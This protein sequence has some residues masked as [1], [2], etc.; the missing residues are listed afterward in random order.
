MNHEEIQDLLEDYVDDRLDRQTRKMV[1]DHL[2]G[3]TECR[4]ILDEVAPVDVSALGTLS[5]D[6]AS[7]RRIVRRS[8][9]RTAW[10][11][12]L[13]LFAGWIALWFFAALV[14]QPLAVNRGG[15]AAD[16]AQATIDLGVMLNQGV[17]LT[18]GAISSGLVNRQIDLEFA[19]A[20][21]AGLQPA[22]TTSTMVGPFG[23]R[24]EPRFDS[25]FDF[26]G[27]QGD[28][29]DQL[30]NLGESTV[31]TVSLWF[32]SPVSIDEAQAIADDPNLDFRVVWAGFDAS[33]DRVEPLEPPVW[34]AGGTLGYATCVNGDEL[35]EDL[36]GATSA[37]FG[38][39][40]GFLFGNSSIATARDS[41]VAA[42]TN[43][44]GRDELVD[45][46]VEPFDDDRDDFGKIVAELQTDPE[47]T[48]LVV[49]GPSPA[50]AEY[51]QG[52]AGVSAN[53]LAVDFYNWTT[54]VCGR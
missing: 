28:A 44:S 24:D 14:L 54:Q 32:D 23:I 7:M 42:L 20:V 52:D 19:V 9:F 11:T 38:Q 51:L 41:V 49:T 29:L 47:V 39:G 46:V 4:Q 26:G 13:L 3:C 16:I 37:S 15:R 22:L 48:V 35:G 40:S 25:Y 33:L 12:V 21:G 5:Y 1:D 8:L 18:D 45:Y 53:V 10:N 31:A 6:E 43:I 2:K 30:S 50:I 34:T 27:F 17:V 36:L